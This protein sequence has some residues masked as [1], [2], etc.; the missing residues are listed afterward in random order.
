EFG[1]R[2]V[3]NDLAVLHPVAH[4]H[5][6]TLVDAGRLVGAHELA[7]PVD[8][9]ALGGGVLV[10]RAHDDACAVDLIDHAGAAGD[11]GGPRVTR[12]RLFHAGADQRRVGLD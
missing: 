12:H 2:A 7:Q 9:D 3:G 4:L 8:V 6:R 1:G 11:D 10:G 5:Q